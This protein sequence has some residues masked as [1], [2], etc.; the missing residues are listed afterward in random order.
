TNEVA[1]AAAPLR[2]VT[3]A[4]ESSGGSGS[5]SERDVQADLLRD[6]VGPLPFRPVTLAPSV[7]TWNSGCVAKIAATIYAEAPFDRLPVLGDALEEAGVT[8]QEV[9][10]HCHR[11]G[12]VHVRGCWLVDLLTGRE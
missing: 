8:D 5:T 12:A 1:I 11:L 6:I 10:G 9:L 2:P 7:R 3:F 4:V